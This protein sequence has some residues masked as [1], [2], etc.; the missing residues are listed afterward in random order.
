MDFPLDPKL[1]PPG[2]LRKARRRHL[3]RQSVLLQRPLTGP[4]EVGVIP[5]YRCNH[6]CIFCALPHEAGGRR[7]EMPQPMLEKIIDDLAAADCEQVSFTGGGE[8]LLHSATPAAVER[9]RTR[10]MACSVCTNGSLVTA[11]LAAQWARLGV[12]LAVSFNAANEKTYYVVHR[13]AKAGDFERTLDVL[14]AFK[15]T[16]AREGGEGS[17]VSMNFV[18]HQANYTEIEAMAELARSVGAAQIQYRLIQPRAV[19]RELMLK[20]DELEIARQAV[21]SVEQSASGQSAFTVQVAESLRGAEEGV[22]SCLGLREGVTPEAFHDDRTRAPCIE[23]YV[24]S[25]IDADGTVFACCLRSSSIGNHFMGDAT[26]TPFGEIWRGEAYQA[27]RRE[28]FLIDPREASLDENSCAY[29]PKA[30]HFLYLIDEF[31]PGNYL[32]LARRKADQLAREL[33]ELSARVSLYASLAPAAMRPAFVA[34]DLSPESRAGATFVAMVTVRNDSAHV[35]PG[36]DLAGEQAVGLGYHL[37]DRRGRMIQF[38]HNPRVYLPRDLAPG[39][40][41]ALPLQVT[42]PAK[43]GVYQLELA[44]VQ[45]HVAWFEQHGGATLRVNWKV[46]P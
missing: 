33:A 28:A 13:G 26:Q 36:S 22:R 17:F 43:P 2:E 25:Y 20:A 44:L 12:H 41:V 4:M 1:Y 34:H 7:G 23:G 37:L 39:E 27:F 6:G 24:A 42:A 14:R 5:T 32:D 31:A 19:H 8:P 3:V 21:R 16:A 9:V 15:Q 40:T 38:D 46:A 29:C 30:K 18:V 35:W 11:E 45:E 10:G